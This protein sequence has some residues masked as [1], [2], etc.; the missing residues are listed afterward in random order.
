M[1]GLVVRTGLVTLLIT[2]IA[3]TVW[4]FALDLF[5]VV[6]P[7]GRDPELRVRMNRAFV[8]FVAVFA[9][10]VYALVYVFFQ[11]PPGDAFI[12]DDED[13]EEKKNE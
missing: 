10:F 6:D 13:E 11:E 7:R 1:Q 4:C 3:V 5:A 8:A 2:V 12:D 9:P